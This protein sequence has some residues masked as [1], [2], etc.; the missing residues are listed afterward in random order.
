MK[1]ISCKSGIFVVNSSFSSVRILVH[2]ELGYYFLCANA[3]K[4]I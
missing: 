2:V 1:A 4:K 3:F